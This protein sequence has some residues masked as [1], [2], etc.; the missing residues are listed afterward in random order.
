[1]P[2]INH[3]QN[4]STLEQIL[5][6]EEDDNH[7]SRLPVNKHFGPMHVSSQISQ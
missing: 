7:N 1:M 3:F 4:Q 2:M 6:D 5:W